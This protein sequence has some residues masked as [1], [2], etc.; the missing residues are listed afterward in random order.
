M[1]LRTDRMARVPLYY[2]QDASGIYF[3]TSAQSVR[4]LCDPTPAINPQGLY[5]Y[6][7]FHMIPAPDTVYRGMS[8]LRAASEVTLT[9]E[10]SIET[11]SKTGGE[12]SVEARVETR[13][14]TGDEASRERR[15][16]SPTFREHAERSRDD[17]HGTL[18][19]RL[20][21]AV[22]TSAAAGGKAGAFLSGGL[23]SSTVAG[24]LS[25]VQDGP[26]EAYAIGF[27]AEGYDEMPYAR[28]TAEHFGI[29]LHEY[30]VT[31]QDVLEAL[32]AIAASADEPF[33]NSS[34]LPAWFC[35]RMAA[36]MA[37]TP[38]SRAMAATSCLPATSATPR[39]RPSSCTRACR[40]GSGP[41]CSSP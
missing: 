34:V 5:N 24:M 16:W 28:I 9:I 30:Y 6:V 27:E 3:G 20:R 23:D 39:T 10:P 15:Y 22:Q 18:R 17:L 38:C 13:T 40:A 19:Q 7:Y 11:N 26:T 21:A 35:A 37:S 14:E 25:E 12:T 41:G 36:R 4:A 8:K 32:P 31:P 33:G 2:A 1:V 29:R